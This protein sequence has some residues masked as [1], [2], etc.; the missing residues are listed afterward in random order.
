MV[1]KENNAMATDIARAEGRCAY[2]RGAELSAC[3]YPRDN[4]ASNE[5]CA[6][7]R[8]MAADVFGVEARS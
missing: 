6:G 4:P 7:W 8:E 5:W 2:G 3:P 1:E